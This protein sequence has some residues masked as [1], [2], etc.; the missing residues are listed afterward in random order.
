MRKLS[1][2]RW[3]SLASGLAREVAHVAPGRTDHNAHDPGI[4]VLEALV[5]V[6]TELGF[7]RDR[8]DTRGRTLAWHIAQLAGSLAAVTARDDCPP[9]MQRLNHFSGQ[10]LSADDLSAEQDYVRATRHRLNRMLYGSGVVS[11]LGVALE[12]M[13]RSTRV[14]IAPGFAF[15]PLGQEIEVSTPTPLPLPAQGKVLLVLLHYAEQPCRPVPASDSDP[16]AQPRYTRIT[17]TYTATLAPDVDDTAV[18]LARV[19]F[20]RGRWT[21]DRRFKATKAKR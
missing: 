9:G 16:Q 10:L 19:N 4:A 2:A 5:Y 3:I 11:G 8:I 21:L 18:A 6:L 7:R 1:D 20:G 14:V 13:G 15:N 12:R 17:E